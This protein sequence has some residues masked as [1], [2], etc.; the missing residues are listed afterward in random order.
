[1]VRGDGV[2][3]D[4]RRQREREKVQQLFFERLGLLDDSD[5]RQ[6]RLVSLSAFGLNENTGRPGVTCVP[7]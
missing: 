6:T 2:P 3:L 5:Q 7:C 1:M 4:W